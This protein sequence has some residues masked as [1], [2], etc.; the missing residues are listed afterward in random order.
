MEGRLRLARGG[1]RGLASPG[2]RGT[3]EAL[4]RGRSN[5]ETA[6][7]ADGCFV[8]LVRR[9]R[10]TFK[11]HDPDEIR[12]YSTGTAGDN[13]DKRIEGSCLRR[14]FASPAIAKRRRLDVYI[15]IPV[16]TFR[17]TWTPL[18]VGESCSGWRGE[19]VRVFHQMKR[20]TTT[21]KK[22][23]S[24]SREFVDRPTS[25]CQDQGHRLA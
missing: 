9:L 18:K 23:L 21:M 4:G 8:L 16:H 20:K 24:L 25:Q 7:D 1:S 19:E 3:L 11:D 22:T 17:L 13:P 10:N 14:R 5:Q 15:V 6:K 2:A 12:D